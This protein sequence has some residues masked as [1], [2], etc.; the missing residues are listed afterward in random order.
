M[1]QEDDG[2]HDCGDCGFDCGCGYPDECEG[3]SDCNAVDLGDDDDDLIF[4]D[5]PVEDE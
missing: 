1:Y 4:D 3:C 5:E 2:V